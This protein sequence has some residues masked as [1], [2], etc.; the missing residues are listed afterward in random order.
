MSKE[1]RSELVKKLSNALGLNRHTVGVRFL[2]S[3]EEYDAC[4]AQAI[5]HKLPYCVMVKSA[6]AGHRI[7]AKAENMGCSGGSRALGITEASERYKSGEAYESFKIFEDISVAKKVAENMSIYRKKPYGVEV[8]SLELME[9]EPDVVIQISD[10]Y[11]IMRLIQGYTY[12]YSTYANF[13][14]GGLQAICSESTAYPFES[15]NINITMMCAGTRYICNWGRD[16][17]AVS[18]PY[19]KFEK[20]ID[21]LLLTIDPLERDGDK[22]RIERNFK[23]ADLL[24]LD[25]HYGQNYDTGYYEFGKS[26]KR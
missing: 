22:Q 21:G 1:L 2:S 9:N 17:L 12:S 23:K 4:S 24:E 16:E 8:S 5:K 18:M 19:E 25:L 13:K 26:G 10:A 20:T 7:K 11:N 14:I 3:V 6:S 15:G